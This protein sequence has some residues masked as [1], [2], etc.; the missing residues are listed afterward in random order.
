[1]NF[2]VNVIFEFQGEF[3]AV[4]NLD[5]RSPF[6]PAPLPSLD[7]VDRMIYIWLTDYLFNTA[8]FVYHEQ[9]ALRTIIRPSNVRNFNL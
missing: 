6:V 3:K 9:G 5:S 4:G 7:E 1:M 2:G 8:S